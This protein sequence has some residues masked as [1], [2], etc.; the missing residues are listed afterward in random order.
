MGAINGEGGP[1]YWTSMALTDAI[2]GSSQAQIEFTSPTKARVAPKDQWPVWVHRV[3]VWSWELGAGS[4]S[5]LSTTRGGCT[6][7]SEVVK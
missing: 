4:S 3:R 5:F 1:I 7:S 6:V 2:F